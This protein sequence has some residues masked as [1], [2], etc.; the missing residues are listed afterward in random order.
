MNYTAETAAMFAA[1]NTRLETGDGELVESLTMEAAVL[2]RKAYLDEGHAVTE[3]MRVNNVFA[4]QVYDLGIDAP[5]VTLVFTKVK[6]MGGMWSPAKWYF[7]RN[8]AQA[9]IIDE[10]WPAI[11]GN[12]ANGRIL[13]VNAHAARVGM[14]AEADPADERP[15][16]ELC[17]MHGSDCA[18]WAV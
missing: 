16:S 8:E 1:R 7:D 4:F 17:P 12:A 5:A 14:R 11:I 3:V 6:N 15:S 9:S 18:A 13:Y 10:P 2:A